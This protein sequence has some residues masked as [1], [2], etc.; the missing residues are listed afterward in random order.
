MIHSEKLV[1]R[2]ISI[3]IPFHLEENQKYLD[4]CLKSIALQ[5]YKNYEVVLVDQTGLKAKNE[6]IEK[7]KF[8]HLDA[9]KMQ[10]AAAINYGVRH[11]SKDSEYLLLLND[12]TIINTY[13]LVVL[14][15]C[16]NDADAVVNSL[17]N[18]DNGHLFSSFFDFLKPTKQR[19]GNALEDVNDDAF[20]KIVNY[21]PAKPP[22]IFPSVDRYVCFYGTFIPVSTWNKVGE[23]DENFKTGWEDNDYC[24]R[25]IERQIP[26]LINCSSFIFHFAG[27][28]SD[29]TVTEDDRNHN[30]NYYKQKW[31]KTQGE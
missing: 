9:P 19:F 8:I 31:V 30:V 6:Y 11:R 5:I 17:S 14:Q 28:T 27:K 1:E 21:L 25:A 20:F 16:L 22:L 18:S 12:D 10:F 15:S 7:E 2:K 23:L 29:K 24:N 26:V 3:I 4:L 13:C